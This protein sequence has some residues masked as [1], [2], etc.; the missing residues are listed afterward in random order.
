MDVVTRRAIF[1]AAC[2]G[3]IIGAFTAQVGRRRKSE[4][5]AHK[6]DLHEWENEG[7]NV[8]P[9]TNGPASPSTPDQG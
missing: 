3:V 8:A 4:R 5:R 2:A 1:L 6:A 9:S 7:G